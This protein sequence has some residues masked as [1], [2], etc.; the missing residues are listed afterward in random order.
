[1]NVALSEQA[2]SL[3]GSWPTDRSR[4]SSAA[5]RA[6]PGRGAALEAGAAKVLTAVVFWSEEARVAPPVAA[7]S[8]CSFSAVQGL[9]EID[10]RGSRPSFPKRGRTI[11]LKE[12]ALPD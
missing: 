7:A 4:G 2:A 9:R 5:D 8:A 1:M 11:Q 10:H 3:A 12:A 6:T